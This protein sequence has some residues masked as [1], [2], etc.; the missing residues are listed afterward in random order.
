[1]KLLKI[2][3]VMLIITT[4][5]ASAQLALP[6]KFE[7]ILGQWKVINIPQNMQPSNIGN[8][9]WPAKCQFIQF[10]KDKYMM[11]ISKEILSLKKDNNEKCEYSFPIN[12][13]EEVNTVTW[14]M[15]DGY[16]KIVR[17]DF[18]VTEY[19][20]VDRI[21]SD[22]NLGSI[23]LNKGDLMMQLVDTKTRKLA[24]IRILRKHNVGFK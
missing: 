24:W 22:T 15:Q 13:P 23:N 20:K 8:K 18:K 21:N 4:N 9:F 3:I 19:W 11:H 16:I 14:G 2:I 5:Q 17:S 1:M 12:R 7:N 6:A 10:Y